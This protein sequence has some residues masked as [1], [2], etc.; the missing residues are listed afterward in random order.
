MAWIFNSV[1][2][3]LK[4]ISRQCMCTKRLSHVLANQFLINSSSEVHDIKTSCL[5]LIEYC[6][7][8]VFLN[9]TPQAFIDMCKSQ[10]RTVCYHW[11][12]RDIRSV[13][14]GSFSMFQYNGCLPQRFSQ[15]YEPR[16][17]MISERHQSKD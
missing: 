16:A 4:G 10:K 6:L 11:D 14:K 7:W 1:P 9:L 13:R 3:T 5:V 17:G 15:T 8:V 2:I 12:S